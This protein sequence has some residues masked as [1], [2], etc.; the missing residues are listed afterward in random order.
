MQ[1]PKVVPSQHCPNSGNKNTSIQVET[2]G[3][4]SAAVSVSKS[5]ISVS[6]LP[7][8]TGKPKAEISLPGPAA[9]MPK[10]GRGAVAQGT[11]PGVSHLGIE[12]NSRPGRYGVRS[13]LK[14]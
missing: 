3:A 14:A 10:S 5:K 4:A 13:G 6:L 9:N 8:P 1:R 2:T 12:K 7:G 11:H